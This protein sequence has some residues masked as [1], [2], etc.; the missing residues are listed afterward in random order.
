MSTRLH[1][2]MDAREGLAYYRRDIC[3]EIS[4]NRKTCSN[5]EV[6]MTK[7]IFVKIYYNI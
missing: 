4:Y 3:N 5:R 6:C 1:N 2:K 7:Q